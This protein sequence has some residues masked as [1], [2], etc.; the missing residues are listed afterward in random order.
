MRQKKYPSRKNVE[1]TARQ[2]ATYN[3]GA[4]RNLRAQR[5]WCSP[6]QRSYSANHF[7]GDHVEGRGCPHCADDL[8]WARKASAEIKAEGGECTELALL[9][10]AERMAGHRLLRFKRPEGAE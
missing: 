5:G 7:V 8:A 4:N 3:V 6:H 10:R 1:P 9:L 2:S